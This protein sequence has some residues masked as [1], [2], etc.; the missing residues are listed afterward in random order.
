M[1]LGWLITGDIKLGLTIGGFEVFTKM[2]LYFFHERVWYKYI[3][4]GLDRGLRFFL[5][6][7]SIIFESKFFYE[8][9]II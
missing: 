1:L 5:T 6:F 3:K 7:K 9:D 8:V 4:Y 2:G